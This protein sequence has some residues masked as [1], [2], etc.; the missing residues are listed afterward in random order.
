MVRLQR[1]GVYPAAFAAISSPLVML[2]GDH[3]PHPGEMIRDTLKAF[4]P[5]LE[6]RSWRLCGHRP[7]TERHVA[8]NLEISYGT[9]L[10]AAFVTQQ[11]MVKI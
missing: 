3:D 9:G 4:M 2:H 6:Y 1:E 11:R 7:W 5:Q 10:K 8:R